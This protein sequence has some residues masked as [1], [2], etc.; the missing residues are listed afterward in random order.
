MPLFLHHRHKSACF[1]LGLNYWDWIFQNPFLRKVL[2]LHFIFLFLSLTD[3]CMTGP[4]LES[5]STDKNT[6]S[7]EALD[8]KLLDAEPPLSLKGKSSNGSVSETCQTIYTYISRLST[9][10][11]PHSHHHNRP[12][13]LLDL[14]ALLIYVFLVAMPLLWCVVPL[15]LLVRVSSLTVPSQSPHICVRYSLCYYIGVHHMY[16]ASIVAKTWGQQQQSS[17]GQKHDSLC[18]GVHVRVRG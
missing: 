17:C 15:R 3:P 7:L 12:I 5:E 16:T 8:K 1:M 13:V 2:N 14:I 11:I 10:C 6:S 9:H 4:L 18:T